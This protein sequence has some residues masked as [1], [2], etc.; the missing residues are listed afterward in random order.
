MVPV[1]T[2]QRVVYHDITRI[3]WDVYA[4]PTILKDLCNGQEHGIV[5]Q[6]THKIVLCTG[7]PLQVY[8][9]GAFLLDLY[10]GIVSAYCV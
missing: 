10:E 9:L 2:H 1:P 4:T 6:P 8:Q 3:T 5:W 7:L